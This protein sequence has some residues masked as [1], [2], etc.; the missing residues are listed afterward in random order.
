MSTIGEKL[1]LRTTQLLSLDDVLLAH[2][3]E[4]HI[5]ALLIHLNELGVR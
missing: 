2:Y 1:Q 5:L 4:R 3:F